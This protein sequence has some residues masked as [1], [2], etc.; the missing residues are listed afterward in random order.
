MLQRFMDLRS[1]EAAGVK[2]DIHVAEV[3][4]VGAATATEDEKIKAKNKKLE[5]AA[6]LNPMEGLTL[7]ANTL[8]AP[9]CLGEVLTTY[10]IVGTIVIIA[11]TIV[12]VVFGPHNSEEHTASEILDKFGN[13]PFI[14]WS[15]CIWTATG[16]GYSVA[17]YLEHINFRDGVKMD[18]SLKPRGAMFLAIMYCTTKGVMGGYTM[19]FGKMFAEVVAE[20][21]KGD[22]QFVKWETYLFFVLFISFNFGME[23]WRQKA[24]NL[25]S[26]MYCVPLFQVA[27]VVFSVFTGAIFF[28]EFAGMSM[29]DLV[30]F[31]IGVVIICLGVVVLSVVTESRKTTP[32]RVRLKG[33][34]IAV[35]AANRL[36]KD[37]ER[38]R[39]E[40][41]KI[42]PEI[43]LDS[44]F[45]GEEDTSP[46]SSKDVAIDIPLDTLQYNGLANVKDRLATLAAPG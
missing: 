40:G 18:G 25:F 13:T 41:N 12:V 31:M 15:G 5:S 9:P 10:D 20:S 30:M 26:T 28:D 19:L 22:N 6:L 24:L 43:V 33:A 44:K 3:S 45:D 37:A 8:S 36:K 17:R 27:L 38:T 34:V 29:L 2:Q 7:V 1:A 32:P 21:G 23:Y 46:L 39:A 16:I 4:E 14:I 42:V 11:G 35:M